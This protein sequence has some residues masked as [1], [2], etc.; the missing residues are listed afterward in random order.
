M[1]INAPHNYYGP[2]D[3]RRYASRAG[4]Y[5]PSYPERRVATGFSGC[6]GGPPRDPN[7]PP[8]DDNMDDY[9]TQRKRIAVACGRC[10]KRKIRC[11][12]DNGNGSPCTNCRNAG[13]EPCQYL[14]VASQEAQMKNGN[15]SYNIDASRQ[16]QT[17]GP[18]S[19]A[20]LQTGAPQY[21]TS[22]IQTHVA[23]DALAFRPG[24]SAT[25][26]YHSRPFDQAQSWANGMTVGHGEGA[27]VHFGVFTPPYH[28]G[29]QQSQQDQELSINYRIGAD[30]PDSGSM[31]FQNVQSVQSVQA[32]HHAAANVHQRALP[33][34]A[35]RTALPLSGASPYRNDSC[36]PV[37]GKSSQSSSSGASPMT[38]GSEASAPGYT[39]YET[40]SPGMPTS[41]AS[42]PAMAVAAQLTRPSDIY[43][44]TGTSEAPMYSPGSAA[45]GPMRQAGSGPDMTYRYTD[46]TAGTVSPVGPSLHIKLERQSSSADAALALSH[47]HGPAYVGQNQGQNHGQNA[48]YTMAGDV[49]GAGTAGTESDAEDSEYK[50]V[51]LRT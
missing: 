17:I 19:V 51:V 42:Y 38:P 48:S 6:P 50:N 20:P 7:E 37:C 4:S 5:P 14:R 31:T 47:L 44:A 10:R 22:G 49:Q 18:V 32:I 34:R 35:R 43:A 12:G 24:G 45:A 36:S 28:Q 15:F 13:W 23:N 46:T 41:A 26:T 11:S 2:A 33:M 29:G 27:G 8:I 30:Q 16:F 40:P 3:N 1:T 21:D 9:S 39:S 25:F